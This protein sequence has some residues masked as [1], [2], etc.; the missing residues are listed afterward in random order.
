SH[1]FGEFGGNH[2]AW[3]QQPFLAWRGGFGGALVIHGH[4]PP[5]KHRAMSGQDDPHVLQYDRLSLDGGS[6]VTG[7]V[8]AAQLEDGRYRVFKATARV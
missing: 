2:W 7:I 3:I 8:A 5:E 1:A 6:A 4:T